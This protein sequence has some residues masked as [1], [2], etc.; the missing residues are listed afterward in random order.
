MS[1]ETVQ[2]Q[3]GPKK[4]LTKEMS[5]AVMVV[6]GLMVLVP[7]F[8]FPT[9]QGTTLQIVKTIVGTIGFVVLCA[10]AYLRP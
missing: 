1:E 6:G 8:F 3:T 9:E 7:W 10:G 2:T 5:I 4:H